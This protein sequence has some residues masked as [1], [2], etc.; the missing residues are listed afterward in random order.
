MIGI[1][2]RGILKMPVNKSEENDENPGNSL[3]IN[4]KS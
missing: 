3:F 4:G 2:L 1:T